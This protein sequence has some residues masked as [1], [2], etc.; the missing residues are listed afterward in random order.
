M[1]GM[2]FV[3]R[4][5]KQCGTAKPD[6]GFRVTS[7]QPAGAYLSKTCRECEGPMP[8]AVRPVPDTQ[9]TEPGWVYVVL[10][11]TG[12]VKIGWSGNPLGRWAGLAGEYGGTVVP[13]ALLPG[14]GRLETH[15]QFRFA[16]FRL[17]RKGRRD[18]DG[19]LFHPDP[20]LL[21]WAMATGIVNSPSHPASRV[22]NAA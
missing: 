22:A 6:S 21:A 18:G 1:S 2:D 3:M 17:P 15:L 7:W 16:E 13:L 4:T 20:G 8:E 14:D 11:A 9:P 12:Y 5:C 19:E 10:L